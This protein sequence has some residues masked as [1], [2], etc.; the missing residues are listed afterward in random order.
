MNN[1]NFIPFILVERQSPAS[2]QHFIKINENMHPFLN[3][4]MDATFSVGRLITFCQN[5]FTSN[6]FLREIFGSKSLTHT[7]I[8]YM[9]LEIMGYFTECVSFEIL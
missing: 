1:N 6:F 5:H 4:A 2:H 3:L 8:V 9:G 7:L